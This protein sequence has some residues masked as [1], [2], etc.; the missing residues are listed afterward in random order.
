MPSKKIKEMKQVLF[1]TLLFVNNIVG[2]N[3]LQL[4]NNFIPKGMVPLEQLFDR[5]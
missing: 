4:K 3:V 1:Q 2:H 5:K